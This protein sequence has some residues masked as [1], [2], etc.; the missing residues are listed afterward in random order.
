VWGLCPKAYPLDLFGSNA[1]KVI[2]SLFS[3]YS[4][5]IGYD[6]FSLGNSK[7]FPELV[8]LIDDY[9]FLNSSTSTASGITTIF[10]Q[11]AFSLDLHRLAFFGS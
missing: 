7:P 6:L 10:F 11:F 4:S 5:D 8:Q 1:W 9:W 3:S 2:P